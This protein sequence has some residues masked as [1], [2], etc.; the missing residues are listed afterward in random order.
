MIKTLLLPIF[1]LGLV[2]L[3]FATKVRAYSLGDT[4]GS[5]NAGALTPT[6]DRALFG[7][8]FAEGH[9]WVSGAD[10]GS[11][12]QRKLYKISADGQDLVDYW[13]Y[14]SLQEFWKGLAYDGEFLY[15]AG[16]DTIYQ[17]DMQSGQRT[18][19]KIKAPMYYTSG[20]AYDPQTDQFW[21]S[22]D[23]N[24]IYRVNREGDVTSSM[25]FIQD[26]PTAGL[27]WDIW[28]PGGPYL[29]VWSSKY[30]PDDVRPKAFQMNPAT[31]QL[32]G[33]S[34]EGVN[35]FSSGAE[36]PLG[37]SLS[38]EV[39]PGKVVFT[40]LQSSNYLQFNDQLDWVVLYELDPENSGISGPEISVNPTSIQNDLMPGDS[41][42]VLLTISN[43]SE[44][45]G[46]NWSASLEY[47]DQ[48]TGDPGSVLN[49]FDFA[50]VFPDSISTNISSVVFLKDHFY[51]ATKQGYNQAAS[52]VKISRDGT[53]IVDVTHLFQ[54]SPGGPALATDGSKIFISSTYVIIEYDP[55][56][57]IV[58]DFI[59]KPNFFVQSMAYDPQNELFYL[60]GGNSIKTI[61]RS[62]QQ[63]NFYTTPFQIRGLAWDR[64]SSGGPYIWAHISNEEGLQLMRINPST[65]G[66]TEISF[67]GV[68]LGN[69]PAFPDHPGDVFVA[70]DYQQNKLVLMALNEVYDSIEGN[71]DHI[72]VYDLEVIPA[73]RWI[74][75]EGF[76]TGST[77]PLEN[78]ELRVR[79]HAIMEDTLMTA[80]V[81]IHSNDVLNPRFI[82]PVN[83]R[84][85]PETVTAIKREEVLSAVLINKIFP[86]PAIDQTT[87]ELN[88][89]TEAD[90]VLELINVYG[91]TVY[92]I[93]KGIML[94]GFHQHHLPIQGLPEGVYFVRIA[95]N[96]EIQSNKKTALIKIK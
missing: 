45:W 86:N 58:T 77:L 80:Q 91:S 29:W 38:D 53:T 11:G 74:S 59:P 40:A 14:N 63:L 43:L 27:A 48:N 46:L 92:R 47:P 66:A 35:I 6:P 36:G 3:S 60:A 26:L 4:L 82:V 72:L 15:G 12:W 30:T 69:D 76:T 90:V 25:A 83:F 75:F 42:D 34:F 56:S 21:V 81:V 49:Q 44:N 88:L 54:S 79:L 73:P 7:I 17:I 23:G 96:G 94:A 67:Q 20:I 64:W 78:D 32:T 41:L 84:M 28:T 8:V 95:I 9:Y 52:L 87:I 50:S 13:T 65:G 62:G 1:L 22:G 71:L 70:A 57:N 68:N 10:P 93:N 51:I 16:I 85:L 18:G 61:N 19:F 2:L 31:G 24:I 55:D 33:V 89:K 5:F 37:L 39:I